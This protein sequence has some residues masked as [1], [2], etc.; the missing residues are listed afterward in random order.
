[1]DA[2]TNH[3]RLIH[4]GR[5][6]DVYKETI[7]THSGVRVD[8]EVV[9][10]P[11]AAAIVPI[12]ADGT[13]LMLSQ[14]RHAVGQRIWEIP[15]GTLDPDESPEFCARRELV[16]ETGFSA[17]E[18][19]KLGEI[20]PLPG[21]SDER[22]HLYLARQLEPA[23][24]KLDEDEILDV[25]QRPFEE[26]IKMVDKGQIVDAKSICGILFAKRWLE[27]SKQT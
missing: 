14:Y 11:G 7:T 24:Q 23:V 26:V 2:T 10:H 19:I 15:A 18:W 12:Q 8:L 1:M 21:Y 17:Q 27:Q 6:F 20:T 22:I 3:S 9:R 13:I 5:V 4:K 25:H 16:E